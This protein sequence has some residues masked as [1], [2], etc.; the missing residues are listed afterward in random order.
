MGTGEI[1]VTKREVNTGR[2][3]TLFKKSEAAAPRPSWS[4]EGKP[5]F[6]IEAFGVLACTC[7]SI[8]KELNIADAAHTTLDPVNPT[9]RWVT[10]V[11]LKI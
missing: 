2:N 6:L 1:T 3:T 11:C 10:Y 5:L 9:L 4:Q 8:L 7:N